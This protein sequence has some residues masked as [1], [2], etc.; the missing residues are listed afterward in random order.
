MKKSI[1]LL[2]A[3]FLF[4][5]LVYAQTST[6]TPPPVSVKK[7][8]SQFK[9]VL[10]ADVNITALSST[11][12]ANAISGA[13]IASSNFGNQANATYGFVAYGT[14]S[15]K[16]LDTTKS[17]GLTFVEG[18]PLSETFTY[19]IPSYITEEA[20]VYLKIYNERGLALATA[21]IGTV[22]PAVSVLTCVHED[23][24]AVCDLKEKAKL[25][26]TITEGSPLGKST[27]NTLREVA[28]KDPVTLVYKELLKDVSAG[29]YTIALSAL[30]ETGAVIGKEV[31]TYYKEG[32]IVRLVSVS[33]KAMIMD[34]Q[35]N[36]EV[37]TYIAV[38]GVP[39]SAKLTLL[40]STNCGGSKSYPITGNVATFQ[41][42]VKCSAGELT[43]KVMNEGT[44]LDTMQSTFAV[45]KNVGKDETAPTKFTRNQIVYGGGAITLLGIL[46]A[47]YFMRRKTSGDVPVTVIALL[48]FFTLS[49]TPT[50]SAATYSLG[51]Q[52]QY[53]ICWI[54]GSWVS[55]GI[56]SPNNT[57]RCSSMEMETVPAYITNTIVTAP[58]Q[59]A[60]GQVYTV[61]VDSKTL[62]GADHTR[63]LETPTDTPDCLPNDIATYVK[64]GPHTGM[65]DDTYNSL[66]AGYLGSRSQQTF[67]LYLD[68]TQP[69][70]SVTLTAGASG[71]ELVSIFSFPSAGYSVGYTITGTPPNYNNSTAM[72]YPMVRGD[73]TIPIAPA[74]T[75][76]LYFSFSDVIDL[77]FTKL[78]ASS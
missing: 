74:P 57:L 23:K 45:Q 46:L 12:T 77:L 66:P 25:V 70:G 26:V 27:T 56:P 18:V 54:G 76:Q 50:A 7:D 24:K 58:N 20:I 75:V 59:V 5:G 8:A 38:S 62:T 29:E 41:M 48:M 73:I 55:N 3:P 10:L 37:A 53:L 17:G 19:P 39:A 31:V 40:A 30:N 21:K 36:L 71:N 42:S 33:S 60:P 2:S 72:T 65:L 9:A 34:G 61:S 22:S 6:T 35:N 43:V 13:F 11:T 64:K 78:F 69:N 44:V 4:L 47:L 67:S 14:K 51:Y 68:R 49:H 52:E 28:S 32:E 16:I 15:G 63:C 1:V